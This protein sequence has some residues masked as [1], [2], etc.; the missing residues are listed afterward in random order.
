VA[1]GALTF[2]MDIGTA[3]SDCLIVLGLSFN[4]PAPSSITVNGVTMTQD[5]YYTWKL[6]NG[7]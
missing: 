7:S 6:S 3:S 5:A 1:S 2:P 4:G